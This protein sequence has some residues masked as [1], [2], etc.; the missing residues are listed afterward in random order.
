MF[1]CVVYVVMCFSICVLGAH[2]RVPQLF[3]SLT[4]TRY[5]AAQKVKCVQDT[6]MTMAELWPD[7]VL[8]MHI[9]KDTY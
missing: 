6:H 5:E 7:I 8:Y 2:T 3:H 1:L 9:Y 4:Q